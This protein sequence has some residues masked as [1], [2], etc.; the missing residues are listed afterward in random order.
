M[1]YKIIIITSILVLLLFFSGITYSMFNSSG[2]FN[3]SDQNIAK[4]VFNTSDLEQID[5]FLQDLKPGDYKEY[6]FSVTNNKSGL[7]SDVAIEYQMTI[8]TFH[9]LPLVIELYKIDGENEV[10]IS[11]CDETYSR[12][13]DN[14]LVCNIPNQEMGFSDSEVDNYKLKLLFPDN[15]NDPAYSSLIDYINI[16]IKSWQKTKN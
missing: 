5:L 12:N 3:S 10:L 6:A 1:K 9:F 2:A 13:T 16:G 11:T 8:K 7:I 15:Y 14:E 4:F